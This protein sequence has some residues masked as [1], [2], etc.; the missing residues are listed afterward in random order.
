MVQ[1]VESLA[2][3][4]AVS[5][6]PQTAAGIAHAGV[7]AV[8]GFIAPLAGPFLGAALA[9]WGLKTVIGKPPAF[10]KNIVG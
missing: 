8:E 6:G 1:G 3:N 5:A 4:N 7:S 9:Y 10:I 2:M